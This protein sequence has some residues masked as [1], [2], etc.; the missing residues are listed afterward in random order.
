MKSHNYNTIVQQL[1]ILEDSEREDV[2]EAN[3]SIYRRS[4]NK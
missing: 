3:Q 1:A 2:I 4:T